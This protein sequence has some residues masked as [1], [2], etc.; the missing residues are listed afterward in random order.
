MRLLLLALVL[1][2]CQGKD[3]YSA[4]RPGDLS[5]A[6]K[7]DPPRIYV[8]NS[9]SNSV[10]VIDPETYRVIDQFPTGR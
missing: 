10:T 3:I 6:V 9:Q 2:H 8:P 4:D 7:N 5:P 1:M